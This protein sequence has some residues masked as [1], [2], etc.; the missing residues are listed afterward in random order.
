MKLTYLQFQL[1]YYGIRDTQFHCARNTEIQELAVWEEGEVLKEQCLY[2]L[3][4]S[5]QSCVTDSDAVFCLYD[6]PESASFHIK[7]GFGISRRYT[8]S[9][10]LNAWNRLIFDYHKWEVILM[11]SEEMDLATLLDSS[12]EILRMP[13][14]VADNRF[15]FLSKGRSY[16]DK[17][18]TELI[19]PDELN[20]ILWT[21][22]IHQCLH[23]KGVFYM[24]LKSEQKDLLCLNI[25]LNG[26]FY[27]RVLGSVEDEQHRKIQEY[28]FEKL[29]TAVNG[30][31]LN[32]RLKGFYTAKDQ[33]FLQQVEL[34]CEGKQ[35]IDEKILY[36]QHWRPQDR[37]RVIVFSFNIHYPMEEGIRYL[38]M[39]LSELFP[40]SCVIAKDRELI[41]VRN[42]SL[43]PQKENY[44]ERLAV[45]LRE[46][47]AKAGVSN[48]FAGYRN[49][50]SAL[51][52]AYHALQLGQMYNPH[53]W[54][55]EFQDYIMEYLMSRCV[56]EFSAQQ[57]VHPGL[58]LLKEYDQA[59][60]TELFRTLQ[61]YLEHG[62]NATQTAEQLFVHRSSLMKRLEKIRSLTGI[63]TENENTRLYLR[64][65][66]RLLEQNK[67]DE[68]SL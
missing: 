8:F 17:F 41:C 15:H 6:C 28:L 59:K 21:D 56:S 49:L 46:N 54:H 23:K 25:I 4:Y 1:P 7:N 62:C 45:F 12:E 5:Q 53:F 50:D 13:L 18:P 32:Q 34:L 31:F 3:P 66:F 47:V 67:S 10:V 42:L 63:D 60:S 64:I 22:E 61:L 35:D 20:E 65:S 44:R 2:L 48:T 43:E 27:A 9:Q 29:S 24:P 26:R 55:Y 30:I 58:F 19:D 39:K 68:S 57:V 51:R 37:Y 38:N 52:Q 16:K 14:A 33:H 40:E 11:Y 36:A